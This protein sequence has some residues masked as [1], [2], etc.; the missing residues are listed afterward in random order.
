[1]EKRVPFCTYCS[2]LTFL[3]EIETDLLMSLQIG[4][5]GSPLFKPEDGTI[6]SAYGESGED[7]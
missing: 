6:K 5:E 4:D 7:V 2:A 3:I 1:M